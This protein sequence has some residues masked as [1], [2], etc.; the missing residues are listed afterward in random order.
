MS[1]A[2]TSALATIILAYCAWKILN[3]AWLKPKKLENFL[4]Q[5]GFSGN[6]YKI[7]HGDTKDMSMMLKEAKARP[8][9]L[10]DDIVPR[11]LPYH[12]HIISKYGKKSFKWMGP[13]PSINVQDPKLIREILLKHDIFQKPKGN[14]LGKLVVNGMVT[15]E[16]EQWSKVRKIA[17]PA[18]H[19]DKLKDMLPKMYLSCN[20]MIR[21]LFE[22]A[23]SDEESFE[24]DIWPHIQALAADVISRTAFGSNYDDGRKIF[25]LIREQSHLF[26]EVSQFDY[27]PGWRFLPTKPN[28]KLKA[29]HH[30][31][32]GLIK[33][34]IKKRE[35]KLRVGKAS[36]D[37]LLGLLMESN[38]KEIQ[39][40][41]AGMSIEEVIEE[42][43][44]FYLAGQETTASLLVWVLVMLCMHPI[45][46]E[47]AR[48]EVF[49]VFGNKEPKFDELNRLKMVGKIIYEVFRI[50]SPAYLIF[51]TNVEETKLGDFILPPGVLLSLPIILVHHDHEYW[52]DGAKVFNPDRFSEGVSKAAKNNEVSFFPFGG[53]PRI[54]IGQNFALMEVKLALAMILQNFSF[55][56][57]PT[58]VHAP[59]SGI[60]VY[61]QHGAHMILNKL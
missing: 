20:H 44:L 41:E 17:N 55:Q 23:A 13:R 51:R 49:Q 35:E 8:I 60:T 19:Q 29:N 2:F 15:Y 53:G 54:C 3:W 12:H 10:S 40:K 56:L 37:D 34:I 14:S 25:E 33:G 27:I 31:M 36:N 50:Y 61:P 42:C 24:L 59:S 57:S 48:Q 11:I 47:R 1:L 4:R 21:K 7:F 45:W 32:R 38:Y 58:Y 9:S 18:F 16:G 39:E 6:S 52:G 22:I 46:Q 28:R 43:K 5:Q 26:I 30:E